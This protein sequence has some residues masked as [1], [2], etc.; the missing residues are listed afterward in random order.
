MAVAHDTNGAARVAYSTVPVKF[1]SHRIEIF[2]DGYVPKYVSWSEY[3]QDRIEE[4]PADYTV[5]LQS[6]VTIGG[7][8]L[9]EQLRHPQLVVHTAATACQLTC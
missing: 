9:D 1:W 4:I 2:R 7:V 6:A 8:V 3:Q 5:R